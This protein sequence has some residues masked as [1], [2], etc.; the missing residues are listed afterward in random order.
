M[1]GMV[2]LAYLAVG[3]DIYVAPCVCVTLQE[4]QQLYA[5]TTPVSHETY[6]QPERRVPLWVKLVTPII[7]N[8]F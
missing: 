1:L 3:N 5:R 6:T 7:R 4:Q 2:K 8:F